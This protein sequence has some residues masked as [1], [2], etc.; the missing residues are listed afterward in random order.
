[1][2]TATCVITALLVASLCPVSA[3]VMSP[4]QKVIQLIDDMAVK[5]GAEVEDGIKSYEDFAKYCSENVKEKGYAIEDADKEIASLGATVVDSKATIEALE[6]KVEDVSGRVSSLTKELATEMDN[7]ASANAD[8]V[9]AEKELLE[10][11]DSIAGAMEVIKKSAGLLQVSGG[12]G[13]AKAH[14]ARQ[15]IDAAVQGLEEIVEASF[16]SPP[17]REKFEAFLQAREDDDDQMSEGGSD[18]IIETLE[19]MEEEATKS[20]KDLRNK[21]SESNQ[22]HLMLKQGFE[23]E[24]SSMQKELAESKQKKQATLES[25]A[26]AESDQGGAK[27]GRGED[28]TFLRDLKHE[29]SVRAQEFEITTRD[30]KAELTALG[31]AKDILS[32]KFASASFVQTSSHPFADR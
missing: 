2:H 21:E 26:Q 3:E 25:L 7:R 12:R 31:K 22:A 29:C 8:F 6:T 32:Q 20:L 13:A 5:V 10:T 16:V 9:V 18:A 19:A 30:G 27:K 28:D 24:M 15:A 17:Q 4:V 11:V 23:N 1:M 14:Q